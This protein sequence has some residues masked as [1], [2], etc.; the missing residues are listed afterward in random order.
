MPG[1]AGRFLGHRW[2]VHRQLRFRGR[3]RQRTVVGEQARQLG[4]EADD[5]GFGELTRCS[6]RLGVVVSLPFLKRSN[7]RFVLAVHALAATGAAEQLAHQREAD[8]YIVA[9]LIRGLCVAELLVH[10]GPLAGA[11]FHGA[12]VT[13]NGAGMGREIE[14]QLL[15]DHAGQRAEGRAGNGLDVLAAHVV[16]AEAVAGADVTHA[17]DERQGRQTDL[18][19]GDGG[20]V[21][22]HHQAQHMV[23]HAIAVGPDAQ[24]GSDLYPLQA[25]EIQCG[26]HSHCDVPDGWSGDGRSCRCGLGYIGYGRGVRCRIG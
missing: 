10:Q 13:G 8:G 23:A 6:F 4:D 18:G 24:A 25:A 14:R 22:A 20:G 17:G 16:L 11:G 26:C 7:P 1:S 21:T 9:Q 12:L 2:R 5:A 19:C 3:F 15:A